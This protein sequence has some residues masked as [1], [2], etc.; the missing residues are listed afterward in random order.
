MVNSSFSYKPNH[1]GSF[2]AASFLF[3]VLVEQQAGKSGG[4]CLAGA[5]TADKQYILLFS[6]MRV[7]GPDLALKHFMYNHMADG[8][9][10]VLASQ[11]KLYV[12]LKIDGFFDIPQPLR[13][14]VLWNK[15][16]D[17]RSQLNGKAVCQ[18]LKA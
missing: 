16:T 9:L 12:F 18:I 8:G 1:A 14:Q 6:E 17:I 11:S 10:L 7:N 3:E 13:L 5:A 2:P 15:G 4:I